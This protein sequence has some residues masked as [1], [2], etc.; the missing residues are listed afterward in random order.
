[1][2]LTLPDQKIISSRLEQLHKNQN[3]PIINL[4][5]DFAEL[6]LDG[7]DQVF[8]EFVDSGRLFSYE[9]YTYRDPNGD[10][11]SNLQANPYLYSTDRF[12]KISFRRY[13]RFFTQ[14]RGLLDCTIYNPHIGFFPE[15]SSRFPQLVTELQRFVQTVD[16]KVYRIDICLLEK[17]VPYHIDSDFYYGI[18]MNLNHSKF[19]FQF[20]KIPPQLIDSFHQDFC[21]PE[22]RNYEDLLARTNDLQVSH[23]VNETQS[24]NAFV[25]DSHNYLHCFMPN[26]RTWIAAFYAQL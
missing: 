18:R 12:G 7:F 24:G 11:V 1:M 22:D 6:N 2:M 21:Y 23:S 19:T 16:L 25:I 20:K 8:K 4:N 5:Y 17:Y 9:N 3:S 26:A 14:P 15:I 10:F 13:D